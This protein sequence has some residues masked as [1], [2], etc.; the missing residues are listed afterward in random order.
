MAFPTIRFVVKS[1]SEGSKIQKSESDKA[2]NREW[3][4]KATCGNIKV[5]RNKIK[6]L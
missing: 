4:L 1:K 2:Y 3:F 5:H 6:Y